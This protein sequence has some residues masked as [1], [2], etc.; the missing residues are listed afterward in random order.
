MQSLETKEETVFE[1]TVS[2][3]CCKCQVCEH[4]N[5]RNENRYIEQY[6]RTPL[7]RMLVI[8]IANYPDWLVLSGKVVENSKKVTFLE[9]TSYRIKQSS[10]IA[11]R[12]YNQAWSKGLDADAYCKE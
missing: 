5:N 1:V 6:S 10:V 9:I 8:R 7:A 12:T 11:S 3:T 4:F 2:R